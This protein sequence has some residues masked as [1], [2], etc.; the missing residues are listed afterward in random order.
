MQAENFHRPEG[1]DAAVSERR[2]VWAHSHCTATKCILTSERRRRRRDRT[3]DQRQAK[4]STTSQLSLS[5][6]RLHQRTP[7]SLTP[8]LDQ[9]VPIFAFDHFNLF[10]II[11]RLA[12]SFLNLSF[13]LLIFLILTFI[14]L[15]ALLRHSSRSCC[16]VISLA[17]CQLNLNK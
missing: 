16:V 7:H 4:R 14:H 11:I 3:E 17:C 12:S 15:I 13:F 2:Q 5:P 10:V 6:L 1:M 8:E 9:A